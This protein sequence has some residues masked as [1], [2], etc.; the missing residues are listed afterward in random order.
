MTTPEHT[1]CGNCHT[2][3]HQ[4]QGH[5]NGEKVLCDQC[6]AVET[7]DYTHPSL[8]WSPIE[9]NG[10]K[11]VLCKLQSNPYTTIHIPENKQIVGTWHTA[12]YAFFEPENQPKMA[13]PKTLLPPPAPLGPQ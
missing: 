9:I 6:N 13:P 5:H 11:Y 7:G 8:H 2:E 10:V 1:T 3:L 12:G 4:V